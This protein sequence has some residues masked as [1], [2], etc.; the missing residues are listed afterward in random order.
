MTY[1]RGTPPRIG[2]AA[3]GIGAFSDEGKRAAETGWRTLFETLQT[4]GVISR[5]SIF[6]PR[7]VGNAWE[8]EEALAGMIRAQVDG[9]VVLNSAFASGNAFLA[10][11]ANPYLAR[12]PLVLTAPPEYEAADKAWSTNAYSG[13]IMNNH[14]ARR[15]GRHV[16]VLGGWADAAAYGADV[17]RLMR[18]IHAVKEARRE[19]VGRFGDAPGGF[20]SA[21]GDQ[22]AY[23]RLF[24]TRVETVDLSAL[25]ETF[26]TGRAAGPRGDAAFSDRDADD[27]YRRMTDGREVRISQEHVRRAARLYHAAKAMI[28]ANGFTS[29]TFRCWPEMMQPYIGV[30]PCF[31]IGWLLAERAVTAVGCEGDWPAAVMLSL[32]ALLSGQPAACLDLVSQ[33]GASPVVQL[34]HCGIGIPGKMARECVADKIQDRGPGAVHGPTLIGQFEHGPKTGF[35]LTQETGGP[36]KLLVFGGTSGPDTDQNI[37]Y[38]A[39]DLRVGNAR[40]LGELVIGEGFPHHVG[41]AFGDI[42]PEWRLL[43]DFYGIR[44]VDADAG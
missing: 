29:A 4:E 9:L 8:A 22:L 15:M 24:G 40:R 14:V 44:Y 13:L 33:V 17:R 7:R 36:F 21:T 20:H 43:C 25:M 5:D 16:Y 39:A 34:G 19:V 31:T 18:V 6:H 1:L 35:C 38:C 10:I 27:T 23:A 32:G 3:C 12:I 28:E 2:V 26:R 37:Y 41:M 11:A 42:A 30:S